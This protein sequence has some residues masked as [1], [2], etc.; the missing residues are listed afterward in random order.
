MLYIHEGLRKM[1]KIVKG[2]KLKYAVKTAESIL[3]IK[4]DHFKV[5][6]DEVEEVE[7]KYFISVS[8]DETSTFPVGELKYQVLN[9][10]GIE[11]EGDFIVLA[12]F[13]LVDESESIKSLNEQYLD[14]IEAQIAGKATSAQ[15]SM[16][17]GDKSISY[18]TIDELFKLREYFSGKVAAEKG[19]FSTANGGKIKYKWSIR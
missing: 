3:V 6:Y 8:S 11:E 7:G 1:I 14:A 9:T 18:C 13:A 2:F 12:N 10:E 17:V 15:Q 19:N 5:I 4:G 16:S